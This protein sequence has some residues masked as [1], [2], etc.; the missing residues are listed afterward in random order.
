MPAAPLSVPAKLVAILFLVVVA[1]SV[2]ATTDP[3]G[4]IEAAPTPFV[5]VSVESKPFSGASA[6]FRVTVTNNLHTEFSAQTIRNVQVQIEPKILRSSEI[7]AEHFDEASGI[8]TIPRI[9]PG[10]SVEVQFG[11]SAM[12]IGS[13]FNSFGDITPFRFS[14]TLVPGFPRETPGFEL[15]NTT[16]QWF[17]FEAGSVRQRVALGDAGVRVTVDNRSPATGGQVIFGVQSQ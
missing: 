6:S 13:K 9:E 16:E 2:A 1:A 12:A 5:D 10:G 17:M 14:A 8:W 11:A 3:H 15:N 7:A 4:T